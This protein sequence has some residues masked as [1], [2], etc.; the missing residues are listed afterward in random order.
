MQRFA[1]S[2]LPDKS[3]EAPAVG[4]GDKNLGLDLPLAELK[5]WVSL[6]SSAYAAE[7]G[8]KD[9]I[10]GK[11]GG[12]RG[13][14]T[15]STTSCQKRAILRSFLSPAIVSASSETKLFAGAP[16]IASMIPLEDGALLGCSFSTF[17]SVIDS[18]N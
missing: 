1:F 10:M 18:A 17:L 3:S 11:I 16:W 4:S 15:S 14:S 9:Q 5:G 6:L 7:I 12:E 8:N 13:M 2:F